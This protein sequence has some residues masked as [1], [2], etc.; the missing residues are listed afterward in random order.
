MSAPRPAPAPPLTDF[1]VEAALLGDLLLSSEKIEAAL[2]AGVTPETFTD[3]RHRLIFRAILS[4]C[5]GGG[6]PDIVSVSYQLRQ[7]GR[8]LDQLVAQLPNVTPTAELVEDHARI[9]LDLQRRREALD[10]LRS[11]AR[12]LQQPG[13]HAAE[14]LAVVGA[15]YDTISALP[16][17]QAASEPRIFSIG[18]LLALDPPAA[19]WAVAGLIRSPGLTLLY[20]PP[21]VGKTLLLLEIALAVAAGAPLFGRDEFAASQASVF[22]WQL[23]LAPAGLAE[24]LQKMRPDPA[25]PI[26]FCFEALRLDEPRT[27][28]WLARRPERLLILDPFIRAHA[29]AENESL[30]MARLFERCFR[31]LIGAGKAVC[32]AHHARKQQ[33]S[34]APDP[35]DLVRGSTDLAAMADVA[36][37]LHRT[38]DGRLL[39]RTTKSRFSAPL[40]PFYVLIQEGA[41]GLRVRFEG[42]VEDERAARIE[43]TRERLLR[44]FDEDRLLGS[45]DFATELPGIRRDEIR[46]ALRALETAHLVERR[47]VGRQ[48]RWSRNGHYGQTPLDAAPEEPAGG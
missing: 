20:G 48:T 24:Q 32:V 21:G 29:G 8:E 44:L 42:T 23:D 19:P 14:A 38:P 9:L 5:E 17:G 37:Y 2:T 45:D 6:T 1:Q 31:P 27:V 41:D 11:G 12:L 26:S 10:Q 36:L 13:D 25:L 34:E 18:D 47:R 39:L 46:Q 16:A 7:E 3:S 22:C 4:V 28:A 35:L 43:T 33:A 40:P 15:A 30:V